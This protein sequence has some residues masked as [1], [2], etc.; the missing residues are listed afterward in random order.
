[1]TDTST[2]EKTTTR[3]TEPKKWL[4][5]LHNDDVTPMDF[6]VDLLM[7]VFA[8]DT[9]TAIKLMLEVHVKGKGIAGRYTHE[10][11][12]QKYAEAMM[13]IKMDGQQL[14]ISLEQ[15]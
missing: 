3:L 13:L 10:I 4:V 15:E 2:I 6:V 14:K 11:A 8:H 5:V 7:H 1:M 9:Q 12:E